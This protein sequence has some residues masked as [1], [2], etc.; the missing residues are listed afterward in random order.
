MD[1]R[2]QGGSGKT[3]PFGP[4]SLLAGKARVVPVPS[5]N[6]G[7]P[8]AAAYS[9]NFVS[10]TLAGQAVGWV[11]AWQNGAP[12]SGTVV[13]NAV[14]GGVVDN[15]AFVPAG[16]D[17]GIQVLA[18]NNDDLVIDI[19]G[20][21]V[22]ATTVQG[23]TG[24]QGPMGPTGRSGARGPAGVPGAT[25]A[26]GTAGV[27]GDT[28]A[29]G[30]L[31]FADFFAS[32]PPDNVLTINPG[33][34]VAFPQDGP[35]S[36]TTIA[37]ASGS[38]FRLSA[39]GTY[40]VMFQVSSGGSGQLILTLN[41]ENLPYTVVGHD[42]TQLVGM[43]LVNNPIADSILT[44]RNPADD[45]NSIFIQGRA[46]QTRSRHIL[47]SRKSAMRILSRNPLGF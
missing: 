20:Y 42:N 9:M 41:G 5:S 1:T 19:N 44:V 16:V 33:V 8:A 6:C 37:R 2:A 30:V 32:T 28:G 29:T 4:P 43:S 3:G 15:S 46:E 17:G 21:F 14:Q 35:M 11:A 34:D 40:Q 27:K 12:W 24:L 25:G 31:A 47:L 38:T 45:F 10:I 23:P 39:I 22:P 18:T 7:V 13:L 36:G 26:A